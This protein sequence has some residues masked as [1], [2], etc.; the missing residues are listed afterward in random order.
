[1]LG[2]IAAS[3]HRCIAASL[4]RCIAASLH[5]QNIFTTPEFA[6]VDHRLAPMIRG[7]LPTA[8]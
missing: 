1:M 8:V 7:A 6:K 4:H 2:C 5:R 3:L